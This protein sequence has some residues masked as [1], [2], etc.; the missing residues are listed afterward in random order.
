MSQFGRPL[1]PPDDVFHNCHY[2]ANVAYFHHQA[3][4][5]LTRG[6]LPESIGI[7]LPKVGPSFST[8]ERGQ[9]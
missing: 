5:N 6:V 3:I 7:S 4:V 9:G 1:P 8:S 2:R